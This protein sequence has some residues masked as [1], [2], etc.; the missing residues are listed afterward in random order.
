MWQGDGTPASMPAKML[1]E[2]LEKFNLRLTRGGRFFTLCRRATR[3]QLSMHCCRNKGRVRKAGHWEM[4]RMMS[5]C[6]WPPTGGHLLPIGMSTRKVFC[7]TVII[8]TC[9]VRRDQPVGTRRLPLFSRLNSDRLSAKFKACL[10]GYQ[11]LIFSRMV[12]CRPCII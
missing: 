3:P 4:V 12:M 7:P 11:C 9:R 10:R 2:T 1:G 8:C 6:C 5:P